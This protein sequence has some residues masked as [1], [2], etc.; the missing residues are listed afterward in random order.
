MSNA[1]NLDHGFVIR[2]RQFVFVK[3]ESSE[4]WLAHVER[5]SRRKRKLYV[6]WMKEDGPAFVMDDGYAWISV[7]TIQDIARLQRCVIDPDTEGRWVYQVPIELASLSPTG[8]QH[9]PLQTLS[10]E[11]AKSKTSD[12]GLRRDPTDY[13]MARTGRYALT[14]DNPE[15]DNNSACEVTS[16]FK[17]ALFRPGSSEQGNLPSLWEVVGDYLYGGPCDVKNS[18]IFAVSPKATTLG[19]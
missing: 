14:G 16:R 13:D 2:T 1:D 11:H 6:R 17:L 9:T 7:D 8:D 10:A 4:D 3:N 18:T 12:T 5:V 15:G 19:P